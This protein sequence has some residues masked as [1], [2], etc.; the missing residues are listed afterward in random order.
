MTFP[1]TPIRR[2]HGFTLVEIL[3]VV[4]IIGIAAAAI[5]P[6]IGNRDDLRT[7]S[8]ARTLM[9]DLNYAQSRAVSMQRR[10]FVRFDLANNRYDVLD[11]FL[12]AERVVTHP[13]DKDPFV[14][15]LGST[16]KDELKSVG[17]D[18]VA[19]GTKTVLA[20]D[21]LGTPMAY[22]ADT[23]IATPLN[24]AA[25]SR[26]KSNAYTLTISVEPY[27]GELKVN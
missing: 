6:Q 25:T 12:P 15:Q 5:L 19:I 26:L 1:T 9:A 23:H 22:D 14:V 17:F 7:A 13:V 8:V 18:A 27:S 20:F 4:V 21:E 2:P 10:H 3:V 11:Q 24:A 16:R